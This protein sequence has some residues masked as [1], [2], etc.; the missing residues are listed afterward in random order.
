VVV[1]TTSVYLDKRG[2]ARFLL[3]V[4]DKAYLARRKVGVYVGRHP[5]LFCALHGLRRG[6]R[7]RLV[8]RTTQL[9]I[10]GYPRSA[11]TFAVV[12]FQQAQ[13]DSVRVAHHLHAPAQ[14]VRAARWRIPTIV[15]VREPADAV[16]SQVVRH[17]QIPV[18]HALRAYISFYET[19]ARY[20]SAYVVGSFQEVTKEYGAVIQRVNAKF[21]TDFSPFEHTGANVEK[22]FAIVECLN[23]RSAK[24]LGNLVSRPSAAKERLK[25]ETKSALEAKKARS[26]LAVAQEIYHDFA[27]DADR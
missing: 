2:V 7:S 27:M 25:N 24:G 16:L 18:H 9:V 23:E 11:N 12:A 26:L 17:P 4:K 20:R 15:L 13:R 5:Y 14:I 22:V 8:S 19:I 6:S 10:E 21:R 1:D 3:P